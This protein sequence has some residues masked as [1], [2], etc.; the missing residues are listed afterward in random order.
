MLA[1]EIDGVSHNEGLSA[2]KN[3]QARLESLGVRFLRFLD[4]DVKHNMEGVLSVIE[5]WVLA[6]K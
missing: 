5:R 1:I 6:N 3:R 4:E 2:D